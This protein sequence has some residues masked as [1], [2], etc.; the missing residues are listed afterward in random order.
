MWPDHGFT[1]LQL[2]HVTSVQVVLYLDNRLLVYVFWNVVCIK[3][4]ILFMS[5]Q[6]GL[7]IFY[8]WKA[9]RYITIE[10]VQFLEEISEGEGKL[11]VNEFVDKTNLIEVE[12]VIKFQD[13]KFGKNRVCMRIIFGISNASHCTFLQRNYPINLFTFSSTPSTNTKFNKQSEK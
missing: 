11:V 1:L 2:K 3:D 8:K 4:K 7:M 5:S 10:V 6:S 12:Y 9:K 13:S